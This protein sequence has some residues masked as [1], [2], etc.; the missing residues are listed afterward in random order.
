MKK[1]SVAGPATV[2]ADTY[3]HFCWTGSNRN[4]NNNDGQGLQ[5]SDRSN[6]CPLTA[7]QWD[8]L[9]D[10]EEGN[11]G[12]VDNY[13]LQRQTGSVG[14]P[15]NN[16][17]DW[18]REPSYGMPVYYNYA[19][20]RDLPRRSRSAGF[21]SAAA[22]NDYNLNTAPYNDPYNEFWFSERGAVSQMAGLSTEV[23][24]ALCT[25]RRPDELVGDGG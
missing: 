21:T 25:T 15:G 22:D 4:P 11:Y 13:L 16:Y 7:D 12:D 1:Y 10:S 9:S 18:L 2:T 6:I 17:P 3:V 24:G 19:P 5:G 23:L 14:D 8:K 20:K